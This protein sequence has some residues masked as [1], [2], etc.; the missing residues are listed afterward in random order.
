MDLWDLGVSKGVS[1]SGRF[2]GGADLGGAPRKA[3]APFLVICAWF[4]NGYQVAQSTIRHC[5]QDSVDSTF[6]MKM[7]LN[8]V[9]IWSKDFG[10]V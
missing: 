2:L 5:G 7:E 9:H 1:K 4:P 10:L 6:S 3:V 8:F